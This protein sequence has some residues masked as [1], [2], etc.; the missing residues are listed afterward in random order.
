MSERTTRDSG[1]RPAVDRPLRTV[2]PLWDES[3]PIVN[4]AASPILRRAASA[5]LLST[6]RLQVT[7]DRR[8]GTYHLGVVRSSA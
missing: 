5:A 7:Y 1:H 3:R 8:S 2:P 6:R 4:D